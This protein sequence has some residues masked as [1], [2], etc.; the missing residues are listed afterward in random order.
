MA[1]GKGS[2]EHYLSIERVCG[3]GYLEWKLEQRSYISDTL[4]IQ[5]CSESCH[6]WFLS[7]P[8]FP[9]TQTNTKDSYGESGAI[10]RSEFHQVMEEDD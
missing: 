4:R 3:V 2:G 6:F 1:F 9:V 8:C 10:L 5:K 7:F